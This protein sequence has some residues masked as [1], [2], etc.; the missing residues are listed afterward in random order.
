MAVR[1]DIQSWV[2]ALDVPLAR[3]PFMRTLIRHLTGTLEE[4]V[5]VEESAGFFSVVGQRMGQEI[6]ESY[7]AAMDA[8]SFNREEVAE[9]LVDLKHRIAGDFYIIEQSDEKIVL[10]NRACPFGDKVEGRTS[11]CMMTS[12]VFGAITARNLGYAKVEL[13]KTIADG[14]HECRIVVY[15]KQNA[16]SEEADGREY[17]EG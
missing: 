8:D 10:G 5:G 4:V 14:H 1:K 15:L 2:S 6:N 12:N 11:M 13:Q 17:F 7:R 16:E 3:D 9:V